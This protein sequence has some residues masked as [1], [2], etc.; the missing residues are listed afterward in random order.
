MAPA[1]QIW[2]EQSGDGQLIGEDL[3]CNAISALPVPRP[4]AAHTNVFSFIYLTDCAVETL[5]IE[6]SEPRQFDHSVAALYASNSNYF[7]SD[8]YITI[9]GLR[10]YGYSRVNVSAHVVP[11]VIRI[12]VTPTWVSRLGTCGCSIGRYQR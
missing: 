8:H 7:E 3:R 9:T 4:F 5:T 12:L 2:F 11:G 6:Q 1:S 10:R